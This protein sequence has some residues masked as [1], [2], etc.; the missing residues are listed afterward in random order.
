MLKRQDLSKQFEL[1]VQQEIKNFQDASY[2]MNQTINELRSKIE[3]LEKS[4][5][6]NHSLLD[7]KI[8]NLE[9]ESGFLQT[10]SQNTQNRLLSH[11]NDTKDL[12]QS[13]EDNLHFVSTYSID[14]Q[15]KSESALSQIQSLS[16]AIHAMQEQSQRK[17]DDLAHFLSNFEFRMRKEFSN[18]KQ[19]IINLPSDSEDIRREFKEGLTCH[20]IDV[21]GIKREFQVNRKEFMVIE[22]NLE[23]IY[24][25]IDNLKKSGART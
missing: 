1:V 18:L 9:V 10:Q 15:H 21:E 23:N 13:L 14:T 7:S 4:T 17:A 24:T 2:Q 12:T 20:K 19:E 11:V 22:K 16:D 5:S 25:L 6:N 8:K 3:S